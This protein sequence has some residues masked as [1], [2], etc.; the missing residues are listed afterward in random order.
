MQFSLL[1]VPKSHNFHTLCP[2]SHRILA[3]LTSPCAMPRAWQ[4]SRALSTQSIR[5]MI[6]IGD[7]GHSRMVSFRVP[8]E[9][10]SRL[11]SRVVDSL[12]RR[13]GMWG[14]WEIRVR[15]C[16]SDWK[17][18]ALKKRLR[19]WGFEGCWKTVEVEPWPSICIWEWEC[20]ESASSP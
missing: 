9:I 10:S 17:S 13:V 7:N 1:E 5:C 15:V 8:P 19:A 16:N 3:G 12:P 6:L 20:F 14:W 4:C 2:E 11:S 18:V